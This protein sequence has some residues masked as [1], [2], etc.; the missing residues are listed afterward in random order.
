MLNDRLTLDEH[1]SV[2]Q[3]LAGM[4]AMVEGYRD[5]MLPWAA[6]GPLE[7]FDVL[8]RVPYRYDPGPGQFDEDSVEFVQRPYYTMSG[9][10][11]GGDCDDKAVCLASWA[12][13]NG[14][15]YRFRVV[16][17]AGSVEP[18]HV[19][20]EILLNGNWTP[21]DVT[22]S[23]CTPGQPLPWKTYGVSY[24]KVGNPSGLGG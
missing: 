23:F 17:P 9:T 13:L 5:D 8:K 2:E 14:I 24:G 18:S 16:G 22:Y 19:F 7:I 10:G 20:A 21:M 15:P 4:H 3:T 12:V 6:C 11:P 1:V